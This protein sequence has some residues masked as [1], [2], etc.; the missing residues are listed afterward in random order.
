MPES[1]SNDSSLTPSAF[2]DF[3]TQLKADRNVAF[4]SNGNVG[5]PFG[6]DTE[7][8]IFSTFTNSGMFLPGVPSAHL[9]P[10]E[11]PPAVNANDFALGI[12]GSFPVQGTTILQGPYTFWQTNTGAAI[13]KSNQPIAGLSNES[14]ITRLRVAQAK[15]QRAKPTPRFVSMLWP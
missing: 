5:S 12:T 6:A 9:D 10:A 11:V 8:K 4:R 13:V 2:A 15:A 3:S 1:N 7:A 14:G